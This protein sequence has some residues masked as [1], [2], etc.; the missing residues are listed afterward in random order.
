MREIIRFLVS[1]IWIVLIVVVVFYLFDVVFDGPS[2]EEE[3][4]LYCEDLALAID[5]RVKDRWTEAGREFIM[6]SNGTAQSLTRIDSWSPSLLE[7]AAVGDSIHKAAGA[8]VAQVFKGSRVT[9]VPAQEKHD[10]CAC[11]APR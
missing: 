1:H 4:A 8:N 7:A 9:T 2:G 6:I 11:G 5:G 3:C 10:S